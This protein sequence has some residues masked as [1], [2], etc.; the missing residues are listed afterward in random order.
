MWAI[1]AGI[2]LLAFALLLV[3]VGV[4]VLTL[5]DGFEPDI[6]FKGWLP[7]SFGA[8]LT[9]MAVRIVFMAFD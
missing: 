4:F 9:L 6:L 3:A 1:L 8:L 2:I 5:A 7:L